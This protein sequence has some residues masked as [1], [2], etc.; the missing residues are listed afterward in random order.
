MTNKISDVTSSINLLL[1]I[2]FYYVRIYPCK[3]C[4][5]YLTVKLNGNNYFI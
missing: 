5:V 1:R 2:S 4:Y 3:E